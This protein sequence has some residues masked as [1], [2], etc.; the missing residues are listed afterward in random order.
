MSVGMCS[1]SPRLESHL[2]FK[3]HILRSRDPSM[4]APYAFEQLRPTASKA[5]PINPYA[6][7]P[8]GYLLYCVAEPVSAM[9]MKDSL[10]KNGYYKTIW[11][12][13]GTD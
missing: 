5:S 6:M 2:F 7:I 4:T 8:Q 3:K 13:L 10:V 1:R 12:V 11:F 9:R